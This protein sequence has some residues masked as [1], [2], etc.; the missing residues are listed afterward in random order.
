MEKVVICTS[1][2]VKKDRDNDV[3]DHRTPDRELEVL[4]DENPKE[5]WCGEL[6]L[7]L[8]LNSKKSS[9]QL[10]SW[11]HREISQCPSRMA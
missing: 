7:Y 2:D 5:S 1:E 11:N 9:T 3:G 6:S 4:Q 10:Q 8:Y